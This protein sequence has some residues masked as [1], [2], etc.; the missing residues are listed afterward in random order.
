MTTHSDFLDK[1]EAIEPRTWTCPKHGIEYGDGKPDPHRFIDACPECEADAWKAER[2]LQADHRRYRWWCSRSGIPARYRSALPSSIRPVSRSAEAL[3]KAVTAYTDTIA[4]RM[5]AGD[6]LL[7]LG[8]VGLGKTLALTAIVN[9]ACG[10]LQGASYASWPEVLADLKAS[11]S[12]P[13]RDDRRQAV[14]RLREAP[15][16]ALDELGV[17]AMSEFDHG[18]LFGLIDYRY[19]EGLPTLAAANATPANFSTLIG[20]RVA[21]RLR[22]MGPTLVLS[23]DSQRGKLVIAGTDALSEPPGSINLPVHSRGQWR[24]R[25]LKQTG[26][27]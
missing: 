10:I 20:E 11:F 2:R 24:E 25:V 14:D 27:D 23:G 8:P 5:D 13:R 18:E 26:W 1:L 4:E 21:D 22:E 15:L 17:R 7:L 12:G 6:G 16:L 3:E 9:A 19:R